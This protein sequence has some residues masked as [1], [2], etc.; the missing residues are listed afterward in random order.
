M[1]GEVLPAPRWQHVLANH[2]GD[3]LEHALRTE[4]NVVMCRQTLTA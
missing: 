4:P 2:R 3:D 1:V